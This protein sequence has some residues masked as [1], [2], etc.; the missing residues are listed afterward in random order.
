MGSIVER[1]ASLWVANAREG[2]F[3]PLD[4]F[5]TDVAIVGAG[6]T[7]LTVA[8]LLS[9]AGIRVVVLEAG[10]VCAGATGYTTAKVTALQATIY[11]T[12]QKTGDKRSHP[13]MRAR[14]RLRSRP[15]AIASSTTRSTATGST[16]PRLPTRSW[17]TTGPQSSRMSKPPPWPVWLSTSRRRPSCRFPWRR[18]CP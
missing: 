2:A 16:R 11:S 10:E 4:H 17:K 18:R 9:D 6:I 7:D 12:L 1:N 5:E 15:C 13:R 14:T 8:R 3:A